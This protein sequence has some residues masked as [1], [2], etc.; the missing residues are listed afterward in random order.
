MHQGLI[1]I[2]RLALPLLNLSRPAKRLVAMAMDVLLCVFTVWLALSL[3]LETWVVVQGAQ[4]LAVGLSVALALPIFVSMGLYRAI[5]RYAGVAAL[6]TVTKAVFIYGVAY[7]TLLAVLHLP[8]VPRTLGL[9]QPLLLLLTVGA[10]RAL[11]RYLL[12]GE[13]INRLQHQS[14]SKVLIYGAGSAGRQLASAMANDRSMRAVGFLDDDD[15]LHGQVLSGLCIYNPDDLAQ[16][17]ARLEVSDVLLAMPSATRQR[18]NEILE[19]MRHAGVVV[20]TLPGLMDLAQGRVQVSDL[21]DLDIDDLLGRDSVPPNALLLGKNIRNKVVLVTGAGGSIGSELCRQIVRSGT[22]KLLLVDISEFALYTIHHELVKLLADEDQAQVRLLPL[23]ASVRD[24]DRMREIL[25]TWRPNTVYHAAAYKHVPLVEHNPAEGVKN[26]AFGTWTVARLALEAGV[27][28][29][30][31]IS[32]DKAVRPT[33]IMGASKRLAE[34]TLQALAAAAAAQG[35]STRFAMVRFG[36]VL[37]SSGSVVPLFRKQIRANGPITLTHADITRYFM[38]IP[39]AAQ[40]VIQAGAMASGGDVF[41]LDMGEPVRIIDLARRMVELSGLSVRD[42]ANPAGD[43]AIE[44]TGLRPGEKLYE[45]LLIGGNPMLTKHP[46]IMKAHEEF[47]PLAALTAR[48]QVLAQALDANDV[49]LV[50]TL[51]QDLVPGYQPDDKVV[52]WVHLAQ[53]DLPAFAP[54][55]SVKMVLVAKQ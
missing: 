43:I 36:N 53:A 3:R 8:G 18:R 31:L 10:S 49:P 22:A 25:Q 28:D 1:I 11:G 44:I 26:N 9:L 35:A 55:A 27:R 41:V 7:S 33:N 47:L 52:D 23:L 19:Q 15:R 29:F 39:E 46:R 30:V 20:R 54:E 2:N 48:L 32:T 51:L 50:R 16:W 6:T 4:W 45:E 40:L 21:L 5:F 14:V 13:Y 37:G 42:A 38:T 24:E 12:S 17:A 34:M